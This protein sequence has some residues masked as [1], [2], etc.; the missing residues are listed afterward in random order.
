LKKIW[1]SVGRAWHATPRA[2]VPFFDRGLARSQ[3]I[4]RDSRPWPWFV[5][6]VCFLL[7]YAPFRL[8]VF[9]SS[10]FPHLPLFYGNE[11][12]IPVGVPLNGLVVRSGNIS[13]PSGLSTGWFLAGTD[14]A[15]DPE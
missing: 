3:N 12:C 2:M 4:V 14:E 9:R 5:D 7:P 15:Y 1:H 6:A 13:R 8:V 11:F 10:S